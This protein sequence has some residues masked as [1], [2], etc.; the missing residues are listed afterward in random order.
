MDFDV[1]VLRRYF[2]QDETRPGDVLAAYLF[3]SLA[4]GQALP[5]SDVDIAVLLERGLDPEGSVESQLQLELDLEGLTGRPVQVTI[6]NRASPFLAYQ[7]LRDGV[8]IFE[9]DRSERIAF[10]VNTLKVYFDLQPRL[11]S[12][13]QAGIKRIKEVGLGK[14][15]RYS[16]RTLDA[17]RRIHQRLA[18]TREG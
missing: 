16:T 14:R 11:E 7:V 18:G 17:A 1:A 4:R 6:L 15:Q 3:G 13:Q 2:D 9:R 10:Q 12:L 5:S 8:L